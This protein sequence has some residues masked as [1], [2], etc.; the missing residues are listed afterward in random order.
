MPDGSAGV[1]V[2]AWRRTCAAIL[3][4]LVPRA[5]AL[6]GCTIDAGTLCATC[7]SSV[8]ALSAPPPVVIEALTVRAA[9]R[10]EGTGQA[11]VQALKYRGRRD[12]A[13]RV[14]RLMRPL[15]EP[16]LAGCRPARE[17]RPLLVPV[18]LHRRRELARGYNQAAL[19]V[20]ALAP[21][22]RARVESLLVRR[23]ATCS[24][25]RLGAAERRAN[26]AA[27]FAVRRGGRR[28]EGAGVVLVDDVVTTG[29]TLLE[30]TR[31][32]EDA[33]WRVDGAVVAA[34]AERL[35]AVPRA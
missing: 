26:V 10:Y 8:V 1:P 20:H 33:G 35:P 24:Q 34:R 21:E 4:C 7:E 16:L 27:A 25:T 28:S 30:A 18:P 19:L 15:L 23:R 12:L 5:C 32:L 14:A 17:G 31:V 9:L 13:G 11:L 3:D 6:C 2:R 29:A 22:V